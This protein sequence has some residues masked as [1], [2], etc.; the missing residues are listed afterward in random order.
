[1]P[2]V[3]LA[4]IRLLLAVSNVVLTTDMKSFEVEVKKDV[5]YYTGNDASKESHTLDLYLPRGAREYP[6]LFYIHGGGWI[7]GNKSEA[8]AHGKMF[9][10]RGIAFVA[11]NYRLSPGVKHPGHVK[12]VARA[13]AWVHSNLG[14]EGANVDRIF[15]T[16]H[17]AGGHL[18]ALLAT[19]ET[20]LKEH[21][22]GLNNIRGAIPISGMFR[23]EGDN[24]AKSFGDAE[25]C[26]N[27]S[28]INHIQSKLPL[29]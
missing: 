7:A 4:L 11:A 21:K 9:A 27:A 23:I 12:D 16:G 29:C 24:V 6:I 2:G 14:K 18:T 17:S 28:P 3:T 8:S 20:Y 25:A 22:L 19:D 5:P 13:F 26:K 10:S 1:M 15:V